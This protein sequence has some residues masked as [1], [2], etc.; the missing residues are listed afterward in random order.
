MSDTGLPDFATTMGFR[1]PPMP[2][3]TNGAQVQQQQQHAREQHE[4]SSAAAS[5]PAV[6]RT[7][8]TSAT[9]LPQ[10]SLRRDQMDA[11]GI[12]PRMLGLQVALGHQTADQAAAVA[13]SVPGGPSV[14]ASMLH[15]AD[16][17][18]H[19]SLFG[20]HG[21]QHYVAPSV[22]GSTQGV[23]ARAVHEV[24]LSGA[25]TTRVRIGFP[26]SGGGVHISGGHAVGRAMTASMP[27]PPQPG[28]KYVPYLDED[29][30]VGL[31]L[32]KLGG[33]RSVRPPLL[34]PARAPHSPWWSSTRPVLT[35]LLPSTHT[36]SLRF[37]R[38]DTRRSQ[39]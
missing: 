19:G 35:L 26:G 23:V 13:T 5:A 2:G 31:P 3:T 14:P 7:G 30:A 16:S 20:H 25:A 29:A 32:M 8:V 24:V 10:A 27:A 1:V 39:P 4:L 37:R 36:C 11:Q 17:T 34:P 6:G 15:T 22:V 33:W 18:T 38:A 9:G 12:S 28:G 21:L